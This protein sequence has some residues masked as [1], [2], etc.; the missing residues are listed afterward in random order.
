MTQRKQT[1]KQLLERLKHG[2]IFGDNPQ[3]VNN[4]HQIPE[5]IYPSIF[6]EELPATEHTI[7]NQDGELDFNHKFTITITSDIV[8]PDVYDEAVGVMLSA[9]DGDEV[10]LLINSHGGQL[11]SL[12][13]L[14]NA[15]KQTKAIVTG[16]LMGSAAS[17]AGALFLNCHKQTVGDM[18]T[19]MIHNASYGSLGKD[20][21]VLA[22]VVFTNKQNRKFV[23][24]TY[25]Y[26]LS[27]A[28]I[29]SVIDG[30]ELYFDEDEVL[31]RLKV[32]DSLRNPINLLEV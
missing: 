29:E 10:V 5:T 21:D 32:R 22:H 2:I 27:D 6:V 26:F 12:V 14:T 24:R 9:V 13:Y 16:S 4:L 3:G 25:K 31:A 1:R 23:E 28:E 17:A 19:M 30:S 18:T 8:E 7:V 20:R 11:D 15:I